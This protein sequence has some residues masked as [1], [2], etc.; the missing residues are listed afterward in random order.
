M[1]N[2][3]VAYVYVIC[4]ICIYIQKILSVYRI[5]LICYVVG[6]CV[7]VFMLN[8]SKGGRFVYALS[9]LKVNCKTVQILTYSLKW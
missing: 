3:I 4:I 8:Q 6:I 2:E 1:C 9:V 7:R 5:Y